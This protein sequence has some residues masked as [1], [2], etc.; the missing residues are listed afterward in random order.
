LRCARPLQPLGRLQNDFGAGGAVLEEE[1]ALGCHDPH[2]RG[3]RSQ[4]L[5]VDL[6]GA[7][8]GDRFDLLATM[9]IDATQSGGGQTFNFAGVYG[10]QLALQ[11]RLSNWDKQATVRVI[12]QS[13]VIVEPMTTRGVP[14]YQ[15]S[16][17]EGS[18]TRVRPVQEVVIAID[19]DEVALLTEA[20]AV[21]ARLTTIPR[22]GRPDDPVNSR[23]PD[24]SPVSPFMRPG[25]GGLR[26]GEPGAPTDE[27]GNAFSVVETIMGQKRALTAVPRR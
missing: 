19:P 1:S 20:M 21:N 7:L 22:S 18:A 13:A 17:T 6:D 26:A 2:A 12:V 16:L 23:T 14:I 4:S 8:G 5:E 3:G 15:T 10:Q 27:D 11:A 24:L 25:A 9:P